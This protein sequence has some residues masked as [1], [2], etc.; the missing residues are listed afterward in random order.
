MRA[1]FAANGD[2]LRLRKDV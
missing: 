1:L 2:G